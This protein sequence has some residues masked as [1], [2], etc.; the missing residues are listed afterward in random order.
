MSNAKHSNGSPVDI[1]SATTQNT[2]DSISSPHAVSGEAVLVALKSSL[3]GLT[4][5]E[6]VARLE[7]YGRNTLPQAKP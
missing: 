3:H 4:R 5:N 1:T 6:A 2:N 7:Q